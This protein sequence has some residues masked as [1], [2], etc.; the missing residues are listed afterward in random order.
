M[1]AFTLH[2]ITTDYWFN[3]TFLFNICQYIYI[4]SYAILSIEMCVF[5]LYYC[6]DSSYHRRW[7]SE[8]KLTST[9]D[10]TIIDLLWNIFHL[11]FINQKR[12]SFVLFIYL[13]IYL[14]DWQHTL[15]IPLPR[16]VIDFTIT[17][18]QHNV[19]NHRFIS[20]SSRCCFYHN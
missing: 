4:Y 2:Q 9:S 19:T 17:G 12:I 5:V 15:C 18:Y 16:L 10:Y 1:R 11:L 20:K 8:S 14:L 6:S 7:I 13:F 3:F